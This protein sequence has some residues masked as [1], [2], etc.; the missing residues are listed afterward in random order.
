MHLKTSV[1]RKSQKM[2]STVNPQFTSLHIINIYLGGSLGP[3]IPTRNR[4]QE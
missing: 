3:M 1:F 4:A 2:A